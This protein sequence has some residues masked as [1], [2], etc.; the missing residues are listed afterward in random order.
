MEQPK[1]AVPKAIAR[2]VDLSAKALAR[3]ASSTND[4]KALFESPAIV[5][6]LMDVVPKH[7]TPDRLLKVALSSIMKTPKLLECTQQSLI[8][9]IIQ[10]GEV[11]LEPGGGLGLAY[12]VPYNNKVKGADGRERWVMMAQAIIGFRGY[13]HLARQSGELKAVRTR[14][15]HEK[16]KFKVRFGLVEELEHIPSE[17]MDPGKPRLVYC[18]AD[19]KDGGHHMEIMT[20]AEVQ[21]IRARSKAK[22]FGPWVTDEEEMAKKTV[23]RRSQKYWPLASE[24]VGKANDIDDGANVV[25]TTFTHSVAASMAP[26]LAVVEAPMLEEGETDY[27]PGN[28]D[29]ITGELPM[30]ER[31]RDAVESAQGA[32][33]DVDGVEPD[34]IGQPVEHFLFGLAHSTKDQLVQRT[35]EAMELGKQFPERKGEIGAAVAAKRK[36]LA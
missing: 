20:W 10:L 13:I 27:V 35:K 19:F 16:D 7:V 12:L 34:P 33:Q 22:D 5:K 9:A 4:L 30:D 8:Q 31:E 15:V 11:G 1:N 32:G 3:P 23:V 25:D 29:P 21:K 6:R 24:L 28:E 36:E 26:Q 14:I 2:T 17:E 18:V